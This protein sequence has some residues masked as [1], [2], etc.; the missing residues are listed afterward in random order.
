MAL[1]PNGTKGV[2]ARPGT[3]LA[4]T[5]YGGETDCLAFGA[6]MGRGRTVA[7]GIAG[8]VLFCGASPDKVPEEVAAHMRDMADACKQVGGTPLPDPFVER[9]NL[10]DGLE[11]WAINEGAFQCD[12]AASL[13]SGSGGSQVVV[14]LSM[15][16]G[17]A[18]QVFARGAEG[19]AVEHTGNSVKLWVGVGGPLCGQKGNPTHA[20]AISCDRPLRWDANTQKLD[21]APLSQARIPSRLRN[22]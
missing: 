13:L 18:K 3:S 8:V 15:P 1:R 5:P 12:G 4:A 17:H 16:T 19:M 2:A 9:G 6:K 10:A 14:Y 7:A 20:E 21:F 11:F 22:W